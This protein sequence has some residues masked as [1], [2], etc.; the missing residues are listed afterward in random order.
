MA[1]RTDCDSLG[2]RDDEVT[3]ELQHY[4]GAT[5]FSDDS[6]RVRDFLVQINQG[7]LA[8]PGFL[9]GRWEWM[10]F[11]SYLDATALL[12]IG[13]CED[14]G[15]IV[16][17]VTYETDTGFAWLL[18]DAGH[19]WLYPDLLAWAT[20][21]LTR[22]GAIHIL[23]NDTTYKLEQVVAAHGLTVTQDRE[24]NAALELTGDLSYQLPQGYR[25]ASLADGCD[26]HCLNRVLHRGFHNPGQPPTTPEA[27]QQ[28]RASL[29]GSH[30]DRALN[31]VAI[32]PDGGV[33]RLLRHLVRPHHGLR[34]RR[35]GVHRS[36]PPPVPR[37]FLSLVEDAALGH[38]LCPRPRRHI[39]HSRKL[40]GQLIRVTVQFLHAETA[41]ERR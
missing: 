2:R 25:I 36:R 32:T 26:L 21:K 17:L 29:S 8:T 5:G 11:L 20:A 30:L 31:M 1:A 13:V 35:A 34:T 9:W 22:N 39:G 38:H 40:P 19:A 7:G 3:V 18:T 37:M 10:F 33:R 14:D 28:R 15:E 4:T 24:P 41:V 27:I 12:R 16:A 6:H 23:V